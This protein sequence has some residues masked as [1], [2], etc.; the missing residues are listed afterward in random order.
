MKRKIPSDDTLR[1][2]FSHLPLP[3]WH[4]QA[5]PLMQAYIARQAE[6]DVNIRLKTQKLQKGLPHF[7][8]S[9]MRCGSGFRMS[10][11]L[12]HY[13]L[14]YTSRLANHGPFSFPTS[15]NVV[16]AF[17]TFCK[18]FLTF[19]LLPEK[20]HL[21][22]LDDYFEW[23]TSEEVLANDAKI[24]QD[25][26]E[27]EVLHS[28]D[29]VDDADAV[30]VSAGA[31]RIVIA[32]ISF[33]RRKNELSVIILGGENPP[34]P[35]DEEI[36]LEKIAQASTHEG[37][38]EIAPDDDLTINDRYLDGLKGYGKV[39]LLTRFDLLAKKHDV[40][41]L[42]IDI[43]NAYEVYTDDL[44]DIGLNMEE[45]EKK[46]ENNRKVLE[47]Y[48]QFFSTLTS[49]IYLPLFFVDQ[50]VKVVKSNFT[51]EIATESQKYKVQKAFK[52]IGRKHFTFQ[53]SVACIATNSSNYKSES[54]SRIIEPPS[55]TFES[56]GY[57]KVLG[58]NEI[59][60]DIEGNPVV[61]KTWV[62]RIE[63]YSVKS[64]SSFILQEKKKVL[65]GDDPGI[66]YIMRS[67]SHGIDIYKV[68]L[69]RRTPGE[70]ASEISSATGVPL[71]LEVLASWE[72]GH[73]SKVEAEAHERLKDF[74]LNNRREFFAVSL[75]T[76]VATIGQ[77]VTEIDT[78]QQI[79]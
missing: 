43:G 20:E 79:K 56:S 9:R 54:S 19:D 29:F 66:V 69:T 74:R 57:W 46:Y 1:S 22:R 5:N 65:S 36:P 52:L 62:E 10:N 32:G 55:F 21:L 53:R 58:P 18:E 71:P 59:G 30:T 45:V 2:F 72:T 76:L 77:V 35:S 25:C 12:R 3:K 13:F 60:Q 41:Y 27:E 78:L 75:S 64:P 61:G 15:F 49:L 28:Y 34:Y 47:R 44:S 33:V 63:K 11:L 4:P 8:Q 67:P 16:E 31:S 42:N 38:E 39:I 73:C 14:E 51:T 37:K 50:H 24:L 26:M 17:F 68:G 48:A 7:I 23:Y 70:R 6:M 40:R